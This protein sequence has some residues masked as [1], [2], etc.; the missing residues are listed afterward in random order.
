V[1]QTHATAQPTEAQQ[2]QQLRQLPQ[3]IPA[4]S[5]RSKDSNG[6]E[7][8]SSPLSQL[9]RKD[10]VALPALYITCF[11]RFE[12]KR[13]D[14]AITLC[15]RRNGQAILRYLVAQPGSRAS[16]DKLMDVL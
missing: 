2:S 7:A 13:L 15:H 1:L 14:Q 4:D 10:A 5:D 3:L 8:E 11:G 9:F 6:S 12:V 16:V